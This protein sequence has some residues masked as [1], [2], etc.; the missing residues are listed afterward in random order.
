MNEK[1]DILEKHE[2]EIIYSLQEWGIK[3]NFRLFGIMLAVM[4]SPA[5]GKMHGNALPRA[6]ALFADTNFKNEYLLF[7]RVKEKNGKVSIEQDRVGFKYP[8]KFSKT[9]DCITEFFMPVFPVY[10][11]LV[12]KGI[13]LPFQSMMKKKDWQALP[14]IEGKFKPEFLFKEQAD[15]GA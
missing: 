7:F 2:N 4:D 14:F 8:I 15:H 11:L 5:K 3:N 10:G 1:M 9:E 6:K 12:D 13:I